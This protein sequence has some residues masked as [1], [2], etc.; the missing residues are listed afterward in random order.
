MIDDGLGE[1]GDLRDVDTVGLGCSALD[2]F[3]EK[4]D[5]FV[6]L[7]D[8]YG[9]VFD[10]GVCLLE[11]DELVIMRRNQGLGLGLG[12]DGL[13][14]CLGECHT[15]VGRCPASQFVKNHKTLTR[16]VVQDVRDFDHLGHKGRLI[17]GQYI[18]G[19]D[20]RK[21]PI[22]QRNGRN[23]RRHGKTTVC[24]EK[25]D[26]VLP[27]VGRL[28]S[29]IGTRDDVDET[30]RA[31]YGEV[32]GDE[33]LLDR[34]KILDDGVAGLNDGEITSDG[35]GRDDP[36]IFFGIEGMRGS[37]IEFCDRLIEVK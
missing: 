6:C 15:V 21:N 18:P 33:L 2:D 20:T 35:E 32:V 37:D 34:E 1:A 24:E 19:S 8:R 31:A 3:L 36:V 29:H 28:P 10:V 23:L 4:H 16:G 27:E 25:H 11:G 5:F 12:R 9:E 14:D 22:H 17:F 30:V 7:I 13:E 26:R